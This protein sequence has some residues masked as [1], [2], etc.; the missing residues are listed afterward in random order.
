MGNFNRSMEGI[1][2]AGEGLHPSSTAKRVRFSKR[3]PDDLADV[4]TPEAREQEAR[5]RERI[6]RPKP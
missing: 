6:A 5:L 4:M 3:G 2:V 1:M